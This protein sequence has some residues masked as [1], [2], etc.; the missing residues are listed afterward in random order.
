MRDW[1]TY[2]D[3]APAYERVWAPR[4]A[5]PAAD[6]IDLAAPAA[7][8]CI[9][10]VAT[11][12]GVALTAVQSHLGEG[13]FVVGV[14]R[15]EEMLRTGLDIRPGPRVRG[16]VIDLPFGD[17]AFDL[18]VCNFALHLFKK[19]E[20]ALFDMLRVLKPGGK[21]AL[22]AW[23]GSP[24]EFV[25]TWNQLIDGLVGKD[26]RT[27]AQ[28]DAAPWFERFAD[29]QK[30]DEALLDAGL[31]HLRFEE[32]EYR[33]PYSIDDYIDGRSATSS[34]R[35]A[36]EMVGDAAWG[37]FLER[38]RATFRERFTDPLTDFNDVWLVVGT[39]A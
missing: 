19:Y 33:F 39:K 4:F 16:E 9:L 27:S 30:L 14:D 8:A 17:S 20:T 25:R 38:A 18:V 34:G 12:T 23:T 26:L 32:K 10:D 31:R 21:L 5:G 1:R 35:F 15:S 3:A 2:D 13:G 24:D 7:D 11:G 37:S 6:L 28:R 36:R 29:R 22:T